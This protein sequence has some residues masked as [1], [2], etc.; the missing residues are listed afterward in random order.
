MDM[1]LKA[2]SQY[3]SLPSLEAPKACAK[4][5]P[6]PAYPLGLTPEERER[7]SPISQVA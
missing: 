5:C 3:L 2:Y 7:E 6:L 1:I 4:Q